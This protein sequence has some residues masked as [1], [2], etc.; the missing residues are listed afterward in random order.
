MILVSLITFI[1][2]GCVTIP[3]DGCDVEESIPFIYRQQGVGQPYRRNIGVDDDTRWFLC[4]NPLQSSLLS[5]SELDV[6]FEN[7]R[8]YPYLLNVSWF[9]Y[10]VMKCR[11]LTSIMFIVMHRGVISCT[12]K[13]V[14]DNTH[15]IWSS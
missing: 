9:S 3:L 2:I 7:C 10:I 15:R 5:E 13:N 8:D 11:S 4:M 6:T 14:K 1:I 12:C